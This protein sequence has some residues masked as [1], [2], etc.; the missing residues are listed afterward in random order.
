MFCVRSKETEGDWHVIR[1]WEGIV[2]VMITADWSN[3]C[4]S[5]VGDEEYWKP[6]RPMLEAS[7]S[8]RYTSEG[9]YILLT[10]H[11]VMIL[12]KWPT[13]RSIHFYVFSFIFNSVHVLSTLCSSSG[14]TICVNTTSGNCQSVSVTMSCAGRKFTSDLHTTRPPTVNRV[15]FT[16]VYIDTI[17]LSWWWERC[18]RY[19]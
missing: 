13:W 5:E 19:M 10:V 1:F 9:F 18:S 14:E 2:E 12:G 17:C 7:P 6:E 8:S 11:H 15:T 3:W 4:W 16:R